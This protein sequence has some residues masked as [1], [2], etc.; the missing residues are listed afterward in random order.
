MKKTII[1]ICAAFLLSACSSKKKE[2]S[3][4][5]VYVKD[6]NGTNVRVPILIDDLVIGDVHYYPLYGIENYYGVQV[7]I[8]NKT[9]YTI[10]LFGISFGGMY[11]NEEYGLSFR[12]KEETIC[13]NDCKRPK[14]SFYGEMYFPY[15]IDLLPEFMRMESI[16]YHLKEDKKIGLEYS[17]ITKKYRDY[18]RN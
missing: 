6:K 13:Q 14:L 17:Y 11:K 8:T 12:A 1:L 18:S 2:T 5:P 16:Y 9:S 4:E 7:R 15:S 3:N 10:E